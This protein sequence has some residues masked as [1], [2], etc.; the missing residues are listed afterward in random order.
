MN[1]LIGFK[2]NELAHK[3]RKAVREESERNG[4][5]SSYF[6]VINCIG[7]IDEN[8]INQKDIS[9][10]LKYKPSTISITLSNMENDGL[11][12]RVKD[13]ND[14]R[15]TLVKLTKKGEELSK[16]IKEIFMVIE[17]KLTNSL[18]KN[19]LECFSKITVKLVETLERR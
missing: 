3:F 18:D 9:E 6:H 1:E 17:D 5:P 19:E 7:M 2:I 16:K 10:F 4:I 11:I 15:N 12:E 8:K 14:N 13:D